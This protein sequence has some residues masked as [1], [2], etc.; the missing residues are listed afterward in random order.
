LAKISPA[1]QH[2]STTTIRLNANPPDMWYDTNDHG[3][4]SGMALFGMTPFAP[5]D[6]A[7]DPTVIVT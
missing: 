1:E 4:P 6:C 3:G 5:N 7:N 2:P